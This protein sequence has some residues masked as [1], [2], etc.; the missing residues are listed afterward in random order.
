MVD[1]LTEGLARVFVHPAHFVH[2][3]GAKARFRDV[4]LFHYAGD[5]FGERGVQ[6][7]VLV[8]VDVA[9]KLSR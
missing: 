1:E 8:T 2:V 3:L 4:E 6:M 9:G 7:D 5:G